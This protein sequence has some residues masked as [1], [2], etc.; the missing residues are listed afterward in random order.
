MNQPSSIFK[1]LGLL[2]AAVWPAVGFA[3]PADSLRLTLAEA[4]QYGL[5]HNPNLKSAQLAEQSSRFKIKEIRAAALPQLHAGAGGTDF[6]ER[7]TQLLPGE[8]FGQPGKTIPAQFGTRFLY[9][10]AVQFRQPLFDPST[11]TA[12][13]AARAGHVLS[14][15][16]TAQTREELV[17]GIAQLYL[18]LQALEKQQR[19]I[20]GNIERTQALLTQIDLQFKE[21]MIKKADVGQLNVSRLNLESSLSSTVSQYSRLLNELRLLMNMDTEQP[22]QIGQHDEKI[23]ATSGDLSLKDNIRLGIL[24]KQIFVHDRNRKHIKAGY[25][26]AIF[27]SADYGRQWQATQLLKSPAPAAFS[28]AYYS[29]NMNLPIFDGFAKRNKVAQID[30]A[31]QQLQL[32]RQYLT[33]A[34][35]SNFH[36]ANDEYLRHQNIFTA[37]KE[38]MKTAEELYAVSKLSYTEG[39]SALAE[40][41]NA[42]NG[43]REAQAQYIAAMLQMNLAA[44]DMLSDSGRLNELITPSSAAGEMP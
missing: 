13:R 18:Q 2:L 11:G 9:G 17:V 44:L 4:V 27:V 15:L 39:V 12:I 36:T 34:I 35:Q 31:R 38:N 42:E 33:S 23:I 6:L 22:L 28:T 14:K 32:Q 7:P 24:D 19:L 21:G 37:Q 20:A 5:D 30:I 8:L 25:L 43:L 10:G 29:V 3:Q 1:I 41:M 16:Q 26:P 40:L